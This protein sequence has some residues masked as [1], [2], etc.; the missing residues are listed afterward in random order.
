[1]GLGGGR[2]LLSGLIGIRGVILGEVADG[3]AADQTA[4][5]GHINAHV[6][7]QNE[8][9]QGRRQDGGENSGGVSAGPQ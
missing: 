8:I 2:Q 6:P 3:A 9:G 7:I 4:E 5:D 1:A